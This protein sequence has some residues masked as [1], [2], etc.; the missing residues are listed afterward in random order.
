MKITKIYLLSD[1]C[2]DYTWAYDSVCAMKADDAAL[3]KAELEAGTRYNLVHS[4]QV[5]YFFEAYPHLA[6]DLI[7][8]IRAGRVTLNPVRNMTDFAIMSLEEIVRSFYPARRLARR[9]GLDDSYAN[10]QETPT[11]PWILPTIFANIGGKGLVRSLL[12]YECPWA[13]RLTEPPIYAWEGP[14]GGR[15]WVR[16][17]KEDYTEGMFVLKGVDAINEALG[18]ILKDYEARADYPFDA[19]GLV[20]CY[21]DLAPNSKE[22]PALKA[23]AIANYNAQPGDHPQLIDATHADFWAEIERQLAAGAS[24]PVI[25]GDYGTSWEVWPACLAADFAAYRRAQGRALIADRLAAVAWGMKRETCSVKRDSNHPSRITPHVSRFSFHESRLTFLESSWSSLL[26][27]SDH[28]WN[29]SSDASRKLNAALRRGWQQEA[30]AGFD[31]VIAEG[32]AELASR[33]PT[34]AESLLAFNPQ[35]WPRRAVVRLSGE[36]PAALSDPQSGATI[37]VQSTLENGETVGYCVLPNVPSVGYRVLSLD[38][39]L[40]PALSQGERGADSPPPV[41]EGLGQRRH[42]PN[43]RIQQSDSPPPVGEGLGVRASSPFYT[44]SLDPATGAIA[45]LY[46]HTRCVELVDPASLYHLNEALYTAEPVSAAKPF[47]L[48][49]TLAFDGVEQ[50]PRLLEA[51]HNANGPVFDEL[52]VVSA[53]GEIRITAT[54]RLYHALDRVEICNEVEKPITDQKEQ[55]DFVFPFNIENRQYRIETPGVILNPETDR[56][57][58]AGQ[59]VHAVR[60]F[61]DVFNAGRGVTLAM[62]DSGFVQ[63]GQRT[64]AADPQTLDADATVRCLALDNVYDW[65]ESIHDQ[66][67]ATKF[68]FRYRIQGHGGGFDPA[69]ALHFGWDAPLEVTRL[70]ARKPGDLPGGAHSFVEV[71]PASVIITGMRPAEEGGIALRVWNLSEEAAPVTVKIQGWGRFHRAWITDLLESP[72]RE[73]DIQQS[74]VTFSLPGRGLGAIWF[75]EGT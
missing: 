59:S 20:G 4:R 11:A 7:A 32:M 8:A 70:P 18:R 17:R 53:I 40:T 24:I 58:G 43:Q 22:F 61:V 75:S 38:P 21:G 27:L 14:D 29:G 74:A 1:V 30:N 42:R 6:D 34:Q 60:H 12:P 15:V 46:D 71:S 55:L 25:R 54:Y 41:G 69:A 65:N 62:L 47:D 49:T 68:T 23:T 73:L 13:K 10:I 50:R 28:A 67:G 19:I 33:V 5:E 31:N 45:S 35:S 72:R 3:L 52:T 26:S 16:L 51:R 9:H 39:T 37:P 64:T 57:P 2:T 63:F 36:I 48:F 44:L 66:G 56:R